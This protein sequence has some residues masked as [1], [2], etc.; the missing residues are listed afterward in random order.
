MT[1]CALVFYNPTWQL[2]KSFKAKLRTSCLS[3]NIE[4]D[5]E[6]RL[7]DFDINLENPNFSTDVDINISHIKDQKVKINL[8]QKQEK[9]VFLSL[10]YYSCLGTTSPNLLMQQLI[11]PD[12]F[13]ELRH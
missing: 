6:Q 2:S 11:K 3:T 9:N 10:R 12:K 7:N 8:K 5:L 4:G 13:Q 1:T